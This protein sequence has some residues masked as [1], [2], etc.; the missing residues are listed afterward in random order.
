[1]S[2]VEHAQQHIENIKRR[3]NESTKDF[4]ARVNNAVTTIQDRAH[5]IGQRDDV[6]NVKHRLE[7]A[8]HDAQQR[9]E[10]VRNV[11][12]ERLEGGIETGKSLWARYKSFGR[13][14]PVTTALLTIQGV[15]A[16]IP[17]TV[18][19]A[20]SLVT[21]LT[22]AITGA[23][24]FASFLLFAGSILLFV[25]SFTALAGLFIFGWFLAGYLFLGWTT[26]VRDKGTLL[27]GTKSFLYSVDREVGASFTEA[28]QSATSW[29]T[30]AKDRLHISH[31][32][33]HF[34]SVNEMKEKA[35]DTAD[36]AY[37]KTKQAGQRVKQEASKAA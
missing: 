15:L 7:S 26:N 37:D 9:G 36:Q 8:A 20:L 6:Q 14:Q 31:D 19:L 16:L 22:I 30:S 5:D 34:P 2:A 29:A 23:L 32:G 25:L 13:R 27:E 28:K 21:G 1:M 11:A 17:V 33:T 10:E 24:I 18:F 12:R 4:Q 35:E 3:A